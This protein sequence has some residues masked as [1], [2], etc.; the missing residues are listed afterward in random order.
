[1]NGFNRV[2]WNSEARLIW[3]ADLDVDNTLLCRFNI[4]APE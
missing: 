4:S 3:T 2:T 1:M